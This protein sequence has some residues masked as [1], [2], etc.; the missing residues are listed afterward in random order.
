MALYSFDIGMLISDI[1]EYTEYYSIRKM[2]E[3]CHGFISPT[4]IYRIKNSKAIPSA[5]E[6][7]VLCGCLG[8][9]PADYYSRI[10][11]K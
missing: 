2:A 4:K 5:I 9:S 1:S 6:L 7:S 11:V 10:K 8:T 3:N